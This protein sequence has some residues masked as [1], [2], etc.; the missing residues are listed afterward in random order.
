M[1]FFSN[2]F[3]IV[4]CILINVI[5]VKYIFLSSFVWTGAQFSMTRNAIRWDLQFQQDQNRERIF[6]KNDLI[7]KNII[8]I[9][10]LI[11]KYKTMTLDAK[12]YKPLQKS[13]T[14]QSWP[15]ILIIYVC[16][17]SQ[18][19]FSSSISSHFPKFKINALM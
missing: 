1:Q 11:H 10:Q 19:N 12:K 14:Y 2:S 7:C 17:N 15:Q 8:D 6:K 18:K 13:L 5:F 3:V 16:Y 9:L 4:I